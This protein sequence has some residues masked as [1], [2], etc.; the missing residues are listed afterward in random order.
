MTLAIAG[1]AIGIRDAVPAVR[2]GERRADPD[3]VRRARVHDEL[4]RAD[5]RGG[6]ARGEAG[7]H[8][9]RIAQAFGTAGRSVEMV[10]GFGLA[11]SGVRRRHVVPITVALRRLERLER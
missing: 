10:A 6:G 7:L 3:V 4:H 1:L 11:A 2:D 5:R 8:V 9:P